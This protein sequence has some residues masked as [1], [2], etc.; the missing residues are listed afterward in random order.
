M[1]KKGDAATPN[2]YVKPDSASFIINQRVRTPIEAGA[3]LSWWM[4]EPT[5]FRACS[6]TVRSLASSTPSNVAPR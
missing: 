3:P 6:E 5:V 4:L 2:R 1:N